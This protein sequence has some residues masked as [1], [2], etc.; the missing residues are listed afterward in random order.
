MGGH[1]SVAPPVTRAFAVIAAVTTVVLVVG[2]LMYWGVALTF[3]LISGLVVI[4]APAYPLLVQAALAT[5]VVNLCLWR[6]APTLALVLGLPVVTLPQVG[7]SA[8]YAWEWWACEQAIDPAACFAYLN[9]SVLL[10]I[11]VGVAIA[12]SLV[13][14]AILFAA[15]A[16]GRKIIGAEAG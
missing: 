9:G 6:R 15:V 10:P 1:L 7:V 16:L 5:I 14:V 11:A 13:E 8:W 4:M 12:V 3:G 2:S